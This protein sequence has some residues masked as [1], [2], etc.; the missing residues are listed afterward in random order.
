MTTQQIRM[1]DL[2]A[3][4]PAMV[5]G[6]VHS[7][8]RSPYLASVLAIAGV[9]TFAVNG[10]N[11]I[12]NT[13]DEDIRGRAVDFVLGNGPQR[14]AVKTDNSKRTRFGQK[15]CEKRDG[16]ISLLGRQFSR[17]GFCPISWVDRGFD[18]APE[19]SGVFSQT[20]R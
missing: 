20:E 18:L 19:N 7:Y 4:A 14:R 17:F 9:L 8:S 16:G 5:W 12:R 1:L 10:D 11:L 3:I 6:A 15:T 2:L 13:P